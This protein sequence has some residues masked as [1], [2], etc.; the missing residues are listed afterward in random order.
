MPANPE[1][2][3]RWEPVLSQVVLDMEVLAKT[4]DG[5]IH[6]RLGPL[7]KAYGAW[8]ERQQ[9]RLDSAAL[10]AGGLVASSLTA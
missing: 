10:V 5:G 9:Q 6:G 4:P 3:S 1:A 2:R 7:A 8:L